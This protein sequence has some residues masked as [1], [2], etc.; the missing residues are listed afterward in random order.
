MG[1]KP[2]FVPEPSPIASPWLP[3]V[4]PMAVFLLLTA[5]EGW[6][7]RIGAA[8][9]PLR[10]AS[11]YTGKVVLT[12]AAAWF[13]RSTWSDFRGRP[14]AFGLGLS[15]TGGL[16]VAALWIVLDGRYPGLPMVRT[17]FDPSTLPPGFRAVFLP[18]R[19]FGLV[20]LIPVIEELFWRSFLLRWIISTAFQRVPVG[21]VT[22]PAAAVTSALFALAHPEWLPALITGFFWAWLLHRTRS[23]TCCLVSHAMANLALGAYVLLTG[24]WKFW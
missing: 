17:G 3:Y 4:T 18:I 6:L 24:S 10:Y 15:V 16:A 11:F 9:H 19:L 20:V 22:L 7:S 1:V 2:R 14:G 12:L 23:L 5:L 13:S 8:V 21:T